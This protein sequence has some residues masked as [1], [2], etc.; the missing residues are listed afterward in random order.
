MVTPT[1]SLSIMGLERIHSPEALCRWGGHSHCPWCAKEGQNEG[2]IVNHL[3]TVHYCLGL[4]CAICLAFFTTSADT[5]KKHGPH[6]K[7]MATRD[8][9]EDEHQ[10]RMM[11]TSLSRSN[12]INSHPL[13]HFMHHSGGGGVNALS[14]LLHSGPHTFS[15]IHAIF[16]HYVYQSLQKQFYK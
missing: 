15:S 5:M 13:C 2:T 16:S 10:R 7:D 1:E 11:D 9:E 12:S 8:W 3:C 4:V 14:H 6:C